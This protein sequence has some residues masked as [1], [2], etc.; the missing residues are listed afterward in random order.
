MKMISVFTVNNFTHSLKSGFLA[1]ISSARPVSGSRNLNKHVRG[2][3]K[4]RE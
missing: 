2:E 4:R 1:G 3:S